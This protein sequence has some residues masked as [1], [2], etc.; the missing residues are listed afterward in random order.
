MRLH[1][2]I[3]TALAG[4]PLLAVPYDPKV[5]GLAETL[6]IPTWKPGGPIAL[7]NSDTLRQIEEMKEKVGISFRETYLGIGGR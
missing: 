3:L 1:F 5:S 2:C 6:G 4:L 7:G